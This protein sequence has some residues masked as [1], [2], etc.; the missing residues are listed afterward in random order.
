MRTMSRWGMITR[1]D[2][3]KKF[4]LTLI[5]NYEISIVQNIGEAPQ[6]TPRKL[7]NSNPELFGL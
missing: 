7:T 6:K 4:P 2:G 5:V 3:K 1:I